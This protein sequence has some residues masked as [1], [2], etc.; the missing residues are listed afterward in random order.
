MVMTEPGMV[1][2]SRTIAESLLRHDRSATTGDDR[3]AVAVDHHATAGDRTAATVDGDPSRAL[4]Q[5]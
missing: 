4:G 1:S 5:S 2:K 3:T